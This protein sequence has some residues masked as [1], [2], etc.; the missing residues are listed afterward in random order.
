[1]LEDAINIPTAADIVPNDGVKY[2]RSI[3]SCRRT[4]THDLL[5]LIDA[6]LAAA[7]IEAVALARC[8]LFCCSRSFTP[9]T[10]NKRP[11]KYPI[12]IA[13]L[14]DCRIKRIAGNGE[15]FICAPE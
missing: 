7:A 13:E 4:F 9:F 14:T 10:P 8:C 6:V 5:D 3:S 1:M 2:V 15:S 11:I 12:Y